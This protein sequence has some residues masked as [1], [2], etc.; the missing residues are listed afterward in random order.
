[1]N[2]T[3]KRRDLVWAKAIKKQSVGKYG[4]ELTELSGLE[5]KNR[6]ERINLNNPK[7]KIQFGIIG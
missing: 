2:L 3:Q 7:L 6:K 4:E 1:M 5:R